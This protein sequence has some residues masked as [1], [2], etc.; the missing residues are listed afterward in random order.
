MESPSLRNQVLQTEADGADR[1]GAN[2]FNFGDDQS[3]S[4]EDGKVTKVYF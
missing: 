3:T 1:V 4:L 2:A